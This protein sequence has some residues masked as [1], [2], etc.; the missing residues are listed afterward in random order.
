MI[1]D[2]V[3]ENAV[4]KAEMTDQRLGWRIA[5]WNDTLALTIMAARRTSRPCRSA[6]STDRARAQAATDILQWKML[7]PTSVPKIS[8]VTPSFNQ[9]SF[10]EETIQS[11]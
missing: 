4:T 5:N 1:F 7:M 6:W 10:R 11:V 9:G 8:I 2:T 3:H